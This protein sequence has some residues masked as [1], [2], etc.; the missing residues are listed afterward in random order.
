[1]DRSLFRD[2][3]TLRRYQKARARLIER[4][5]RLV[6]SVARR[7]RNKGLELEDLVQEGS[8]GLLSAVERVDPDRGVKFS[9]YA[10]FWIRQAIT[11]A[12]SSKAR[13][14]RVP[15]R[16]GQLAREANRLSSVVAPR[17]G[18]AP[19]LSDLAAETGVSLLR[20]ESARSAML[21]IELLDA[22]AI[23]DGSPRWQLRADDR[24]SSPWSVAVA[25][26]REKVDELLRTLPVRDRLVV[27][28]RFALGFAHAH[29]LEE[30]ADVLLL[31]RERVR[32]IENAALERLRREG[33]HRGLQSL[34][35]G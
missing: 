11:R 26:R 34:A 30:I 8:I 15:I 6:R 2:G 17:C 18:R 29:T 12:L 35:D 9:T 23:A 13:T 24:L 22:P 31:S 7:Y 20:L 19:E 1:L 3:K 32:Q 28:M 21:P 10:V 25:E 14:I 5:L 4:N 33:M 27:R 16:L